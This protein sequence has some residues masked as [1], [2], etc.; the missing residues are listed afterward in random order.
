MVIKVTRCE[1]K[2]NVI[3]DSKDVTVGR[4]VEILRFP[5]PQSSQSWL[6]DRP[7]PPRTLPEDTKL[8]RDGQSGDGGRGV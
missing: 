7:P 2:D 1:S 3:T 5:L 8:A 4:K 6:R